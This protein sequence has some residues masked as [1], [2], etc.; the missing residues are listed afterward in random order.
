METPVLEVSTGETRGF[1]STGQ[2]YS[3]SCHQ[4]AR[5]VAIQDNQAGTLVEDAAIVR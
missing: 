2:T 5:D 3:A 1:L 4:A